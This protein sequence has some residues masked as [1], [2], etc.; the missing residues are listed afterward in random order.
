MGTLL[1]GLGRSHV[2]GLPARRAVFMGG[3]D[4]TDRKSDGLCQPLEADFVYS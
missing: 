2:R 1:L 4:N 3:A